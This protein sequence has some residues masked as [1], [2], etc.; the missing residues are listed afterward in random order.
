MSSETDTQ[1][2]L[3]RYE[4]KA[5]GYIYEPNEG[6][7]RREIPAGTPFEELPEDWLCPVCNAP[8]SKFKDIGSVGAPSGFEENLG[9]GLGVNALPPGQK[10][11]LIFGALALLVLFLL[12]FYSLS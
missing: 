2:S 1:V 4:C 8:T 3:K 9:Y 12:S 11:L 7:S 10:N 5:C 6:D